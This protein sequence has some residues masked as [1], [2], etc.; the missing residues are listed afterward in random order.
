V[1]YRLIVEFVL[2]F[3]F[4]CLGTV[5]RDSLD[6]LP[7]ASSSFSMVCSDDISVTNPS[8][9]AS[10]VD[11][12]PL[13]RTHHCLLDKHSRFQFRMNQDKMQRQ[14]ILTEGLNRSYPICLCS[15]GRHLC[16]HNIPT[17]AQQDINW[18][19]EKLKIEVLGLKNQVQRFM[20]KTPERLSQVPASRGRQ[21]WSQ[22]EA[23]I[24]SPPRYL[25]VQS[26]PI[27]GRLAPRI[28]RLPRLPMKIRDL[29]IVG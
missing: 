23:R 29:I 6:K 13:L 26:R 22:S 17:I 28:P 2:D 15:L 3:V 27:L 14:S 4:D 9:T 10:A 12:P 24:S 20:S 1:N 16:H 19:I 21:C 18:E 7:H 25:L 5:L 11:L 8:P